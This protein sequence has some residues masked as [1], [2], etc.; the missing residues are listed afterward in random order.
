MSMLYKTLPGGHR[1]PMIGSGYWQIEPEDCKAVL[2]EA[3]A[4]GYRHFDFAHIYGN[5]EAIG[6]ALSSVL[7]S[8]RVKREELF[9]TSKL[10]CTMFQP[11]KVRKACEKSLKDLQ[12]DYLDL[13]L[14]HWPYAYKVDQSGQPV[15]KGKF[16][17]LEHGFTTMDTWKAMQDLQKSGL[18][19]NIGVSNFTANKIRPLLQS[20]I[21]PAVNQVELHPSFSQEQLVQ[22]C[23]QQGIVVTAYSPLG[24]G[25][26][27]QK[28]HPVIQ[29][30]ALKHKCSP[31]QVVL[32]WNIQRGV[33]VIPKTKTLSRLR[34]NFDSLK[35]NLLDEDML[36][37][38]QVNSN[39][40]VLTYDIMDVEE[41]CFADDSL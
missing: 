4:V 6:K 29:A 26:D 36:E 37:L 9:I 39:H 18:V 28:P 41:D 17:V 22:W 40:R 23:A 8:G 2:E 13:Y 32:K 27:V 21:R 33:A 30:M 38:K 25:P 7:A 24:T 1:M 14:L 15:M 31:S 20:E 3:V 19:R 11:E 35:I 12:L 10:W 16:H 5:E 34:E